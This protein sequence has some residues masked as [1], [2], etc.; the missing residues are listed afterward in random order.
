MSFRQ[1]LSGLVPDADPLGGLFDFWLVQHEL[2]VLRLDRPLFHDLFGGLVG[3]RI[4]IPL[5]VGVDVPF[6]AELLDLFSFPG[7]GGLLK[8]L[9]V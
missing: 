5:A 8:V 9:F 4:K 2:V 3:K 1:P 6:E 7:G